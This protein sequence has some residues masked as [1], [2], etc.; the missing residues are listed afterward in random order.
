M[1]TARRRCLRHDDDRC[2]G[3]SV[4]LLEHAPQPY[5][6]HDDAID[7]DA[8]PWLGP[9]HWHLPQAHLTTPCAT[10]MTTMPM[11][12]HD[13]N[14]NAV[15]NR[16][17]GAGAL[18]VLP[19]PIPPSTTPHW[20]SLTRHHGDN[21][22]PNPVPRSSTPR[23]LRQHASNLNHHDDSNDDT[24]DDSSLAPITVPCPTPPYPP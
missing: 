2:A 5:L 18:A 21:A 14:D 10:M 8:V 20:Y 11:P 24:V 16:R 1:T 17:A 12:P 23:S 13:G 4:P 3:A 9:F 19:N 6:R 22:V 7:S 15:N